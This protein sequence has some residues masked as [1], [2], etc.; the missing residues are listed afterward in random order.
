MAA[1]NHREAVHEEF[2][3]LAATGTELD[4][5][6]SLSRLTDSTVVLHD[7]FAHETTRITAAGELPPVCERA[8]LEA[9]ISGRPELGTIELE[10]R[11]GQGRDDATFAC[12]TPASLWDC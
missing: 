6:T 4:V 2:T 8:S 7:R 11:A 10:M 12:S 3:R 1:L 5:A 9:V